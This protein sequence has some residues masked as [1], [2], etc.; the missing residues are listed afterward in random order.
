MTKGEVPT[1]AYQTYLVLK[2]WWL[3][4]KVRPDNKRGTKLV[5]ANPL[6]LN[7]GIDKTLEPKLT[8]FSRR[9]D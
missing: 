1:S 8:G 5:Q 4:E 9:W 7:G 6:V 3:Q 2:L